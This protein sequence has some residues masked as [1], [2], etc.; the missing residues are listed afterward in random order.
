MTV[1]NQPNILWIGVDQMRADALGCN[2]NSICQTPHLDQL[3]REGVNFSRAYSP[4]SLCTPARASMFTGLYAFK[5]GM[6][7]NCD[8]YHSLAAELPH[9][10]QLLHRQLLEKGYRCGF[11][12]KWHVGTELGP[13]DY[14]FEGMNVPGYG[15]LRQH[16]DYVEYLQQNNLSY[17]PIKNPIFGNEKEK[18]LIAGEWN[19]SLESTPTYF[20]TNYTIDLLDTLAENRAKTGQPFFLTCQYW[21]PHGPYLPS[22]EFVGLHNRE[23]IPEW[24]NFNDDYAGKPRSI[25]RFRRDFHPDLPT[26]WAGWQEIVGLAYDYNTMVDAEIGRLL[27]HLDQLGLAGDT[28]V[29]FTSDH[30]DM[31]G[32]HGG[33]LDKGFMY[34]EAH[35]VPLIVRA[36]DLAPSGIV[37]E[38]LVYNMDIMPTILSYVDHELSSLDGQSLRPYLNDAVS[39]ADGRDAIYLEFHGIRCLHTQRGLVR[40]DGMKYIFNPVDEDELYDL[41]NDPGEAHNL[42]GNPRYMAQQETMRRRI[43]QEAA[44]VQDPVQ[45]YMAKLFGDYDN[46]A[47]QPDPSTMYNY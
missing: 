46:L 16:P 19:G 5:H 20:L 36:P 38:E 2:G 10:E 41:S 18:T 23:T 29:F 6:G 47:V 1:E 11:T 8:L 7:T 4:S 22:R 26:D 13:L 27:A 15:D 17:G 39:G 43:V 35:R 33:L 25:G 21:A 32:S 24:A 42:L 28:I 12:G 30:G 45:N 14:G 37:R 44:R 9:P 3:A 31:T 40:Q 34:E